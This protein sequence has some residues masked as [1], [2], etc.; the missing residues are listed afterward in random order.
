MSAIPAPAPPQQHGGVLD[1]VRRRPLLSFVVLALGLSWLAWI[2]YILSNHG[3]GVWDLT[4]PGDPGGQL[5]GMLPGAY[6]GPIGSA[7]LVTAIADG[8]PGLRAWARR[9]WNWKVG[10]KWYV[11][12]LLGVPA[13]MVLSGL[14]VAGGEVQALTAAVVPGLV[15]GLFVQMVT[16]GLAEEPGW[17]D[18]A[19][20]RM[21]ALVGAPLAALVIGVV[22][23]VWHLPLFLTQWARWDDGDVPWFRPV[24]FVA[25]CVVFNVVMT[26]VFNRTG[27]S[28]PM[29]M[30]LHVSVNNFASGPWGAMFPG[31]AHDTLQAALLLGGTVAAALV[32][33]GTRGRLGYH[34]EPAHVTAPQ[35]APAR[36]S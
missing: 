16:T 36:L 9:L 2:P 34:P 26:W 6:L 20:P 19:L 14:V 29:A 22:W 13:A 17:R 3:L 30:L 24:V 21:Q 7:L 4:F 25:F 18:F 31:L 35:P 23:G 15:V 11:G 32:L 1:V 12:I 33:V 27:Q 10:W 8:R 28:L 5:L